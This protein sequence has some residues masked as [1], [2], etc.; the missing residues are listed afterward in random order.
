MYIHIRT[1][2]YMCCVCTVCM[3]AHSDATPPFAVVSISPTNNCS[4]R[5]FWSTY[6]TFVCMC[7]C[8]LNPTVCT[9]SAVCYECNPLCLSLSPRTLS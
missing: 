8:I 3:Y 4:Y 6:C 5:T 1:A 9:Y 7:Y 2:L